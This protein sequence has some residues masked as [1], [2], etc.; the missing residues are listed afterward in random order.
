MLNF[1]ISVIL[2]VIPDVFFLTFFITQTKAK[3][4]KRRT[5]FI[6][7]FFAYLVCFTIKRYDLLYY[8]F[9][10]GLIY[11]ILK[12]IYRDDIELIDIVIITLAEIHILTSSYISFKIFGNYMEY[13]YLALALDKILIL[14]PL[15][16]SK[17]ISKIYR[18]YRE[19]WDRNSNENRSLKSITIRN[20]SIIS[21]C[22]AIM[23][24]YNHLLLIM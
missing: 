20:L 2:G 11:A 8:S 7:I 4:E 12:G 22:L 10:I 18:R 14:L 1:M 16:F 17:K 13:Y 5:T 21:L 19:L 23:A 9:S 24:I 15:L 6:L 3:K